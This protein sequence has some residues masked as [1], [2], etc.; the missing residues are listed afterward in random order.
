MAR[1]IM[2]IMSLANHVFI[3]GNIFISMANLGTCLGRASNFSS[4]K[5]VLIAK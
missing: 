2:K 5:T 4:N 1:L 3:I